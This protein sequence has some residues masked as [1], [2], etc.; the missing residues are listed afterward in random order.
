MDG[1]MAGNMGDP[2]GGQYDVPEAGP[3]AAV[4]TQNVQMQPQAQPEAA[5][6]QMA[7]QGAPPQGG[8]GNLL[9][10]GLCGAAGI[11]IGLMFAKR[12]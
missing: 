1:F 6:P 11:A 7:P 3:Y 2:G 5:G 9:L 10:A 4:E 12:K 8:N